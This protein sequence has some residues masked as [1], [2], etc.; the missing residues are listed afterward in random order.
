MKHKTLKI[1][2]LFLT[3]GIILLAFSFTQVRININSMTAAD[4]SQ[5]SIKKIG[6]KTEA[7]VL[8]AEPVTNVSDLMAVDGIGTVKVAA[9]ERVFCTYD[10]CRFQIFIIALTAGIAL[11][12]L[13]A[14]LIYYVMLRRKML[15]D[16]LRKDIKVIAGK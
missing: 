14:L 12:I 4:W 8:K 15:A 1:G 11:I 2:I 9:L 6:V 3:A 10:T 7:L 16:D 5:T 13:G